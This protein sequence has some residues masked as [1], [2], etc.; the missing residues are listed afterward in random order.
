MQNEVGFA[1][2][3]QATLQGRSLP[4]SSRNGRKRGHRRC[5][6][7]QWQVSTNQIVMQNP[8]CSGNRKAARWKHSV[9][10][11]QASHLSF[12]GCVCREQHGV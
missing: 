3:S 1:L 2:D 7:K 4:A 6:R 9:I 11:G 8:H 12:D 5:H 10:L